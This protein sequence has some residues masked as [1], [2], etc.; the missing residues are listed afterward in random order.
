MPRLDEMKE[1]INTAV[2]TIKKQYG[3]KQ[4]STIPK[5]IQN[6]LKRLE[7]NLNQLHGLEIFLLE[8]KKFVV[9]LE[10]LLN[11]KL[12]ELNEK[13]KDKFKIDKQ[14]SFEFEDEKGEIKK[15]YYILKA[16]ILLPDGFEIQAETK[17]NINRK[18]FIRITPDGNIHINPTNN[19]F[20]VGLSTIQN[21]IC[22][23]FIDILSDI[24]QKHPEIC[25]IKRKSEDVFNAE[26]KE[27]FK[28]LLESEEL[29]SNILKDEEQS[30]FDNEII[31]LFTP[32]L[33]LLSET[34]S[35]TSLMQKEN[36]E[37]SKALEN[38]ESQGRQALK[39]QELW[40]WMALGIKNTHDL[41]LMEDKDKKL[42]IQTEEEINRKKLEKEHVKKLIK[43]KKKLYEHRLYKQTLSES[44]DRED[45]TWECQAQL[46]SMREILHE[47]TKREKLKNGEENER[48]ILAVLNSEQISVF[49]EEEFR[50]KALIEGE[51]ALFAKTFS[52]KFATRGSKKLNPGEE[53]RKTMF[54]ANT[55][56]R[57]KPLENSN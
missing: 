41:K 42:K 39:I 29:H 47:P 1:K 10:Y 34:A 36:E 23:H 48:Q 16:I 9:G 18:F 57:S 33:K 53:L 35:K 2:N 44:L 6:K 14:W 11:K 17:T 43:A 28:L 25:D 21:Y 5:E 32:E 7:Y 22:L 38:S 56:K 15:S 51:A 19:G 54:G 50:R 40:H 12:I 37:Q 49:N 3:S 24:T 55:S 52:K 13:F 4:T 45:L 8:Y 46:E 26:K 30:K 20:N 31:P 27:A